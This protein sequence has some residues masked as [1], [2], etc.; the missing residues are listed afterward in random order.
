MNNKKLIKFENY[1]FEFIEKEYNL[2]FEH[3]CSEYY[4]KLNDLSVNLLISL[5]WGIWGYIFLKNISDKIKEFKDLKITEE[6]FI[7]KEKKNE[8]IIDDEI[9]TSDDDFKYKMENFYNK[10]FFDE[11]TKIHMKLKLNLKEFLIIN[12]LFEPVF[13]LYT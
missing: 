7:F 10:E 1:T 6:E 2:I 12:N 13:I 4:L 5:K 8:I 11:N 3:P 9:I